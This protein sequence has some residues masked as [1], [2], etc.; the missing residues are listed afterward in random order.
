MPEERL[1]GPLRSHK[2]LRPN[3]IEVAGPEQQVVVLLA[4]KQDSLDGKLARKMPISPWAQ[5]LDAQ[6]AL[7]ILRD[8]PCWNQQVK[9]TFISTQI[10]SQEAMLFVFVS[11][12]DTRTLPSGDGYAQLPQKMPLSAWVNCDA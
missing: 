5:H 2:G 8:A 12:T 11:K 3:Q 4:D 9:P 7:Y 6:P 10:S 1:A